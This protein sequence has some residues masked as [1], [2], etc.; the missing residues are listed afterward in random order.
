MQIRNPFLVAVLVLSLVIA[1]TQPVMAHGNG[2]YPPE[3]DAMLKGGKSLMPMEMMMPEEGSF[4]NFET[5]HVHPVDINPSGSLLAVVNTAGAHIEIYNINLV[6]G[7][8]TPSVS[9][10]V[11]YDPVTARWRTDNELWVIN[12][13]SDSISIVNAADGHVTDTI[14]TYRLHD[15]DDDGD[16]E[17]AP[18]GD[19]PADVVFGTRDSTPV[20]V[21]SCS[22]TDI[23]QVYSLDPPMLMDEVY[24]DGE[25]PRALAINPTGTDRVYAAIFESG[26]STTIIAGADA[27]STSYPPSTA[28][29][30]KNGHT[31]HPYYFDGPGNGFPGVFAINPPPNDGSVGASSVTGSYEAHGESVSVID[32]FTAGI[33]APESPIIVKK[34]FTDGDKWKDDN[35]QD[36]TRY[37]TGDR[38]AESGR[39]T[40]W[41]M[42]DN[43][44]AIQPLD[45]G[46]TAP[47][48]A[49]RQMNI[50]MALGINPAG[51]NAGRVYMVG[52]DA[53]N[54]IRFEPNLTGTFV[55]VLL[56]IT[57][58]NGTPVAL[59]D[60][61][62]AHLDAA[63][64][65]PGMAYKDGSVPQPDRNK[66]IGD[67]RGVA[68]SND[69]STVYISGMG[70]N[71]IVAV[72]STTGL[73]VGMGHSIEVGTGPTGLAH[74]PTLD[75]LY[76]VN[77]FDSTVYLLDTTTPGA[78]SVLA[79]QAFF[80][81]T[82]DWLNA[83]RVHFYSTHDNSGLGQ[84]AC[85]SCHLDGR[86]DRLAWDLGNPAQIVDG[87]GNIPAPS[88]ANFDD[89][90]GYG[91]GLVLGTPG[92]PNPVGTHN[93][94]VGSGI[95]DE[96]D[97]EKFHP[98]KGAMTTQTLQDIIGK[99]PHHWR[100]D[101]DGIEGFAGA[102]DGLQGR[103]A[104]LDPMKMMEFKNFLS[105]IQFGPNPFRLL[106]N[107]LPGGPDWKSVGTNKNLDM[108]GFFAAPAPLTPK[109][110]SATGTPMETAVPGGGN[111]WDGFN[112][113]VDLNL[114]SAFRCVDCH[115]LPIGAGPTAFMGKLALP[116]DSGYVEIPPSTL[117]NHHQMM[118][119]VDGTGQPHIKVP[120][121]RNQL[122]KEGFFLNQ[123]LVSRA[124]FG[125]VHDGVVDG[126]MRFLSEPA[127]SLNTDQ[128]LADMVAFNLAIAGGE[129]DMLLGLPGAP[130]MAIPPA[131]PDHTAHAAVGQ[132]LTVRSVTPTVDEL[133]LIN[134]FIDLADAGKIDLIIKGIDGGDPRGWFH[135]DGGAKSATPFMSDVN[136]VSN[137]L[138]EILA[139]AG[140]STGL[141]FST[142]PEGAGQRMGVDR[143]EDA[144]F[145]YTEI[146]QGSDPADPDDSLPFG[147][148]VPLS[149]PLIL[150]LLIAILGYAA[151]RVQRRRSVA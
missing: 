21:V 88:D 15:G 92:P 32:L 129:F 108:K 133:A 105:S 118:V 45:A 110:F 6:D 27:S 136:G 87:L 47:T 135:M 146:L 124:G 140:S 8:L 98:M 95:D 147:S 86:M 69:G 81:P 102:F 23:L 59:V 16:L 54:E 89:I 17:G 139:L 36:W 55:R 25:D 73:R 37:I 127:F 63:Q 114:D 70:S 65:G 20:A 66:S 107:T 41:D 128:R 134:L 130:A 24:L 61:N 104:P 79:T 75:R 53:T 99:E 57:E 94:M 35:G 60:L 116:F 144:V 10:P 62:E 72:D 131:A 101:K 4:R 100:G 125:L 13:V 26:N 78:E 64:G 113:Y 143:D 120:Q 3:Y 141:T 19:E 85:A 77:K 38:A 90:K 48:Y 46:L 103:D 11:G 123:G 106:D 56:S 84:I 43:D 31:D 67:P 42:L 58:A 151:L 145:D 52:T 30:N 14:V 117:G 121:L 126:L 122:D 22:R 97:F 96:N 82:P 50:C 137:S 5:P 44:I 76:V 1:P 142:V 40:G 39:F 83:G 111:A 12:Q 119:S 93:T 132:Q 74:H 68:F 109:S 49:T 148:N 112:E 71:N 91:D 51:P 29:L 28:G 34:D 33:P 80:D 150:V 115:T 149:S 18:N 7:S 138:A 2:K 9:V